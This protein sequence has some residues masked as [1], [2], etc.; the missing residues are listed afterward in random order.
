VLLVLGGLLSALLIPQITRQWQDRQSEKEIK[1]SLLEEISTSATTGIRQGNSL[2]TACVEPSS[3]PDNAGEPKPVCAPTPP[4]K[5]IRAAG[6]EPGENVS[7]V[8]AVLRNNW[9]IRRSTAR[10]RIITYF[11]DLYGCWYSYERAIADYLGLVTQYPNSKVVRAHGLMAYVN[12]DFA[13]VYSQPGVAEQGCAPLDQLP[14]RVQR[15]FEELKAAMHWRAL[16]F[17]TWNSR[18]K[19]EYAKL[20]ELLEIAGERIIMTVV[21]S[22]AAGFSHGIHIH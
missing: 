15:R 14:P 8:Y 7:E 10:S 22:H 17:P 11:P 12:A 21:K 5:Q 19:G 16:E 18:F 6:G 9:L 13:D 1:R 20:G 4:S 3:E 2:V